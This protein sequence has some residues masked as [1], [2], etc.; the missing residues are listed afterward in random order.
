MRGGA[1]I[2]GLGLALASQAH[3]ADSAQDWL[4]RISEASRTANYR[5]VVIY[6]GDDVLETFRVTH[7]FDSGGERERVQSLTGEVREILKRDGKVICLLPQDQRVTAV[8]PTPKGLFPAFTPAR[9]QQIAQLYEIRDLGSARVAGRSCR[10]IAVAPRDA[11]RYGYEVW[12]DQETAVPLKVSLIGREHRMLE[13]MFFTEVDYPQTIADAAFESQLDPAQ[14]RQVT[15]TAA[16]AITA[17]ADEVAATQD[18]STTPSTH[19]SDM[20]F[21]QLP[22]GFQVSM[23]DVRELPGQ[24]GT[25]EHVLLSDGLTAISIFRSVQRTPGGP[26]FNGVRQIGGMQAF[27]RVV[28]RT[29]VTVVGEA[30]PETLRMIGEGIK[31]EAEEPATPPAAPAP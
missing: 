27:G 7:R 20:K 4:Y 23:R 31:A 29:H 15:E 5:G 25:V 3:A 22:P 6:H 19:A 12:A 2:A 21:G 24:R 11:Y 1:W 14:L 17:A 26:G 8:R 13:Q 9:I 16:G 10:G 28:G 30:P 18:E